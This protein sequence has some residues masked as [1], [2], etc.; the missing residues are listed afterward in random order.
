[1][2]HNVIKPSEERQRELN[3]T[4]GFECKCDK[5]EPSEPAP[6]YELMR[7]DPSFKYVMR[8]SEYS[9][10]VDDNTKRMQLKKQCI[11]F[12]KK[13]GHSWTT[14]LDFVTD[15]FTSL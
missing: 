4:W 6:E 13:Y 5:C 2:G 14:E 11:K 9:K 7:A 8:Y 12:L 1:M 15:C 10:D 3:M